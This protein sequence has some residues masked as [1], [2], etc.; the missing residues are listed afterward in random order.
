MSSLL[1]IN[2]GSLP[3][4]RSTVINVREREDGELISVSVL[5]SCTRRRLEGRDGGEGVR[6]TYETICFYWGTLVVVGII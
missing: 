4:L 6:E 1:F 3:A 2:S 5:V